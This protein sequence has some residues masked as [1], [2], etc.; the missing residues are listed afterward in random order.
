MT[1]A[2]C[3]LFLPLA[4]AWTDSALLT[5]TQ[6]RA[7]SSQYGSGAG[8]RLRQ[9]QSIMLRYKGRSEAEKLRVV[10]NFFNRMRFIDDILHWKKRDY[11]ATPVEFLATRGGDCED[12]SIAKYFTLRELGIPAAKLRITYVKAL[13]LNQAHMVLAYYP[14]PEAEP[15]ILDNL[16]AQ[17]RPASERTDLQPVYSF[18]GDNLWLA[19]QLT[20]RGRLVG[21]SDRI[22]LW[23]QVLKRMRAH[24]SK[25]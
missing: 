5:D 2:L 23:Q 7:I 1:L 8:E 19:K 6:I 14:S 21:K 9:W 12:F 24:R 4:S 13:K 22:S 10:N 20:G 17:I 3:L 16:V 11:W 18:N 15:L 25:Q